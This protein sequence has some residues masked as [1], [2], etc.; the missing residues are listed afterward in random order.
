[1]ELS[2]FLH[3][4]DG[5]VFFWSETSPWI[6]E[7]LL[8]RC[9]GYQKGGPSDLD[10]EGGH[11]RPRAPA[12][13]NRSWPKRRSREEYRRWKYQSEGGGA[14]RT[15]YTLP[16]ARWAVGEAAS[17]ASFP[18]PSFPAG[19]SFAAWVQP[20]PPGAPKAFLAPSASDGETNIFVRDT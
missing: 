6:S 10:Q 2:I 12:A 17:A 8:I 3:A 18:F 4:L 16:W 14:A 13:W 15:A 20:P 5:L 11:V 7:H 1:M 9:S 19:G